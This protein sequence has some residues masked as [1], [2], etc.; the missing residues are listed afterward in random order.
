MGVT[1][2]EPPR[3]E[4]GLCRL[5]VGYCPVLVTVEGGRATKV[6]G[7]PAAPLFD[8]YTCPKG[9]ALPDLLNGKQRLL[10]SMVRGADGGH[11]A[12]GFEQAIK[13]I[14]S[15]LTGI[16]ERH[17]PEAVAIYS[18]T[19]VTG[20]PTS[21]AV[22]KAW[23]DALGS[24]MF[25][26]VNT[27]DKPGMQI[28]QA[29]H[30]L[31][32][33]GH[34]A[35]EK[36]DAWILVGSN[37]IISKTGGF[38]QNNPG[39]RLKEA[40]NDRGMKLIVIDPRRS[41]MARRAHVH[42]QCIPGND[43]AILSAL[44]H[45]IIAEK[46]YDEAFIDLH[47]E[48][49][50]ALASAVAPFTPAFVA[51]R[52]GVPQQDL[53]EAAR[54]FAAA[55][56]GGIF[57]GT[58]PSFATHGTLTEYLANCLTTLCGH[59]ARAGDPLQKPNV[60][61]PAYSARA[62]P[63]APWPE[64]AGRP[65]R[66]RGLRGN[67]S[68]M[69]VAAL[70]DEILLEGPGQIRALICLGGNPVTAFPDH[71]RTVEA[72][73]SLELFVVLDPE[74]TP[75]AELADYVI[76]PKLMLELPGTS[77]AMEMIKY[78]GHSRGIEVPYARYAPAVVD[79]PAGSELVAD[80]EV[81]YEL[82]REMG[83]P[84]T[85][86]THYG[87]S[88]SPEAPPLKISFD[89]NRRPSSDELIEAILQNSRIP[90]SEVKRYPHGHIFV[91][92]Q[93]TVQERSADCTARLQ[94]GNKEMMAE[95]EQIASSAR[96]WNED[97]PFLL[98]PRRDNRLVNSYGRG[99][100]VLSGRQTFNP[101]WLNPADMRRLGLVDGDRIRIR[102]AHGEIVAFAEG[103]QSIRAGIISLTHCFGGSP[104]KEDDP[105]RDGANVAKLLSV[106]DDFDPVTGIPRMGALPVHIA[107]AIN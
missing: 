45:V 10:H 77:L 70:P 8:G 59:W 97:M 41:E 37:P 72:L 50:A 107:R 46:L 94:I 68:G 87:A 105:V 61:L 31:W 66:V 11:S 63:I 32:E 90:L 18:G 49:F 48:G 86:V 33:A 19:G 84:L 9:R 23:L 64:N 57:C 29:R 62:Q 56:A 85:L 36:A 17:G 93:E 20:F 76:A 71:K 89:M 2:I 12:I 81:F 27:I 1:E 43:P 74:M 78:L 91:E 42:L 96:P 39:M 26:S 69:P 58:G 13:E 47:A 40:V 73:R 25:F 98:V 88:P 79:P 54:T 82:A 6:S 60:L 16:V 34:P 35:F 106:D 3:I 15:K 21:A 102:S 53:I 30:G 5:C 100:T 95:L 101:G 80:W 104:D 83:L 65:L 28:A 67:A 4:P 44:I 51:K 38:P 75:T 92:V 55:R 99:S 103:D 14:A 22:A 7:D 24:P 52:A